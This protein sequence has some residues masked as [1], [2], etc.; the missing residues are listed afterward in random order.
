MLTMRRLFTLGVA[1]SLL[2]AGCG[3]DSGGNAAITTT[4]KA[5]AEVGRVVDVKVVD[6]PR[7]DPD[8]IAV[9]VGET[10]TFKVT[11]ETTDIHEFLL[12]DEAAQARHEKVMSDMGTGPMAMADTADSVTVKGGATKDLTYTFAKAGTVLY[13]CHQPGHY[14]AGQKGTITVS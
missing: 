13:G 7:F 6:G 3:K 5:R 9:T 12:G 2:L 10:I 11:N 4:A 14:A 1:G 8:A